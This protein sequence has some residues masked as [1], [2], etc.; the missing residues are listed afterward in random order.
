MKDRE[1]WRAAVYCV[2]KSQ[3]RLSDSTSQGD[4]PDYTCAEKLLGGQKGR[5]HHLKVSDVNFP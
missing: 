4:L 2:V 3:I 1:A 5:V